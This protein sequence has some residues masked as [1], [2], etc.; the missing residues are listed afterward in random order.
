MTAKYGIPY[1]SN[2]INSE[3][4]PEDARSMCIDKDEELLVKK[5]GVI[6]KQKI[7]DLVNGLNVTFDK[8]G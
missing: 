7:G 2:F 3:M 5:D 6:Q 8:E 4:S 1:F